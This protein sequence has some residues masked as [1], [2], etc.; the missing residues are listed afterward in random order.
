MKLHW[1]PR[2][3]FVRK[4][5][6]V[7][8]EKGMLDQVACVRSTVAFAAMP[9]REL[10]R[11]NPL[12]KL[13][14]LVLDDHRTLFDS[15][16]ICEYLDTLG[17]GPR[18]LP[19]SGE[20]RFSQLRWQ[21]LGDG[22]TDVLLLWRT[23]LTRPTG[24]LEILPL[25]FESKVRAT[26]ALLEREAGQLDSAGFGLGHIGIVC[27]LGQLDFRFLENQW[28]EAFPQ[29]ARWHERV[30]ARESIRA[31]VPQDDPSPGVVGENFDPKKPIIDFLTAQP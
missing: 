29:L 27:A 31:T 3:P 11:D 17:S 18:L 12:G 16:V 30:S 10:Q 21:A 14:T 23:E 9:N 2:S 26:M 22:L 15:R 13:P 7:L 1:S 19:D 8:Q 5:M 25:S 28:R 4:V 24:V 20:A 6:I